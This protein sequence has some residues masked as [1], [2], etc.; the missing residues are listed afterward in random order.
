M[1]NKVN[2][3]EHYNLPEN[4]NRLYK[5]EARSSIA[6]TK[7]AAAKINEIIDSLNDL[8]ETNLAKIHEQDGKIRGA[9]LYMKDNLV[10]T[11]NDLMNLLLKEGYVDKRIQVH[12]DDLIEK[13]DNLLGSINEGS[14]TT[15]D[16]EVIDGRR[17]MHEHV[18]QNLGYNI[19]AIEGV[20]LEL[21]SNVFKQLGKYDAPFTYNGYIHNDGY[22]VKTEDAKRTG[23]VACK[24]YDYLEYATNMG[25]GGYSVIFYDEEFIGMKDISIPGANTGFKS[26]KIKIKDLGAA[27]VEICCYG[28]KNIPNAK[29]VLYAEDSIDTRI[30]ELHKKVESSKYLLTEDGYITDGGYFATGEA[31][32]TGKINCKGYQYLDYASNISQYGLEVCLYDELG[33]FIPE[34]SVKGVSKFRTNTIDLTGT[35]A[36]YCEVS[37]YGADYYNDAYCVLYNDTN[38]DLVKT[39]T[40]GKKMLIFGDSITETATMDDWGNQ[41]VEKYT[42][43]ITYAKDVLKVNYKNYAC[44]GA[45][46]CDF[47]TGIPMQKLSFQISTCMRDTFSTGAD[48]IVV[49]LGT[50]DAGQSRIGTFEDAMNTTTLDKTELY[51]A[52]RD[53]FKRL[54]ENFPDAKCFVATPIQR[55]DDVNVTPVRKAIIEMAARYNFI[56]IDAYGE[57]GI[58]KELSETYLSDGLH[59]NTKGKKLMGDYYANKIINA[60]IHDRFKI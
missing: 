48:I 5:D 44:S 56:V 17:S 2:K 20:V 39:P 43:W 34:H 52:I 54:R 22:I 30:D 38:T 3:I 7:D 25:A 4:T 50:N 23:F 31:K 18:Y 45:H 6:L 26:G 13:V 57:S 40:K 15:M 29:C 8:S 21:Q 32:R 24:G 10:N 27:Y 51:Q 1:S 42:N 16:A 9:I 47:S 59:P 55:G 11:L 49:S 14:I 36:Y 35:G 53:S 60:F 12:I 37:C 28:N 58:I 46:Y 33:N 41:Y 19:R